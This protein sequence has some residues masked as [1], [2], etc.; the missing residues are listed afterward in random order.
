MVSVVL[1]LI[2][3]EMKCTK[4]KEGVSKKCLRFMGYIFLILKEVFKKALRKTIS[5]FFLKQILCLVHILGILRAYA[6]DI[7][8]SSIFTPR[9]EV[10]CSTT[11]ATYMAVYTIRTRP[12]KR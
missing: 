10:N 8:V 6:F 5:Y 2:I 1:Q 4:D 11:K 7:K 3:D 9:Q 12:I